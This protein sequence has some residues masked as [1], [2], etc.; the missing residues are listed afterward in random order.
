MRSVLVL[1]GAFA[2][3]VG[4]FRGGRA[5]LQ[6]MSGRSASALLKKGLGFTSYW[7]ALVA[8]C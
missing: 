2:A 3:A 5:C 7:K 6:V 1:F 8:Y 4:G